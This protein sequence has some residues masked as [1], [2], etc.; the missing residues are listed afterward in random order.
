MAR[1]IRHQP[2]I[3]SFISR[4]LKIMQH[5]LLALAIV[6]LTISN[7]FADDNGTK[8]F[9]I[10][11]CDWSLQMQV[12][13]DSFQFARKNGLDG[14]QYSF[15]A[16]GR[17][18]DLRT[19]ENRNAVRKIVKDTGVA[20]SSLGIG[21]LN[22]IPLATTDEAD[23]L[24]ADCLEAMIKLK[25]EAAALEDRE[26]AS[27][28]APKIVLLAFFGKADLNGDSERMNTVIDKLKRFAPIAEKHGFILGIESLLSEADHRHI[29]HSV[30]SPA[31]KVYYDT[32]NSDRMGYDIYKEI[33]NLG[34]ENI[35]EIHIKQDNALLGQGN[36]DFDRIRLLLQRMNYQ[37]WL[38]IE[39]SKPKKM[40]RV[41][42]TERNAQFAT[43]FFN[44]LSAN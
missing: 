3:K 39:G 21:L 44:S 29:L 23:Q 12:S 32:A 27:K 7:S 14:I 4:R 38:I 42:A 9:Q 35:C 17:G 18:L 28:V 2:E 37:G 16:K 8:R 24:V 10:G 36:I 33:E 40:S 11:T 6:A 1:T 15:D 43:S 30:G 13:E 31:V 20:I 34:T 25:D 19:L 22:K 26:L 41:E 5:G